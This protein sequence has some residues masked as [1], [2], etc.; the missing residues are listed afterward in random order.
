VL[1]TLGLIFIVNAMLTLNY[2]FTSTDIFSGIFFGIG[3]TNIL[4]SGGFYHYEKK[5]EQ[6][7]KTS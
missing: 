1:T 6:K 4:L 5:L 7:L 3:I 2:N